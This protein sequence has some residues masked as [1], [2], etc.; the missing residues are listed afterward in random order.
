MY[1]WEHLCLQP[2]QHAAHPNGACG[3]DELREDA[4]DQC[5]LVLHQRMA[6]QSGLPAAACHRHLLWNRPM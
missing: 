4:V 2:V 1:C 3:A 6:H 5:G